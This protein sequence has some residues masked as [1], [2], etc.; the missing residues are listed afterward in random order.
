MDLSKKVG[1]IIPI[2]NVEKY[3]KECLDSIV[4]QTYKNL[5]ILLVNDGSSDNSL[6]IAKEYTLR[7]E[8]III[9]DKENGGQ[10]SAR[11]VGIEFF[12]GEYEIIKSSSEKEV[13]YNKDKIESPLHTFEII[14]NNPHQIHMIYSLKPTLEI[15]FIDYLQF[16]DSDDYIELDCVRECV[17]RMEG[18]EI[19]WLDYKRKY[20]E[21][22]IEEEKPTEVE[23]CGF[24]EIRI[25]PKQFLEKSCE[26]GRKWY[27]FTWQGMI[28]FKHLK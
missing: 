6:E 2:Y 10:G 23:K 25:T 28:D 22:C 5:S 17:K 21:G 9:F 1:I 13:Q 3:L 14:G 26:I 20:E 8:R 18:V 11:N 16:V 27:A 12:S 4:N 7:D 24:S 15:P 19:V